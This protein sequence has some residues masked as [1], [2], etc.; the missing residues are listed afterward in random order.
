MVLNVVKGLQVLHTLVESPFDPTVVEGFDFRTK[1]YYAPHVAFNGLAHMFI[2]M[3]GR[4]SYADPPEWLGSEL[5]AEIE[6]LTGLSCSLWPFG[7]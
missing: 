6:K 5:Q 2:V 1:L 4:L 3:I 7:K